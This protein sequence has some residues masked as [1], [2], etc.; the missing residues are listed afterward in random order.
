MLKKPIYKIFINVLK[1][2]CQGNHI[3]NIKGIPTNKY[4]RRHRKVKK[5]SLKAWISTSQMRL[6]S[7][8]KTCGKMIK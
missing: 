7:C 5:K 8:P 2:K 4:L 1:C 3:N 6:F